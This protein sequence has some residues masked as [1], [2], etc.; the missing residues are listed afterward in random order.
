MPKY[1][2]DMAAMYKHVD[3]MWI[4]GN[5]IDMEIQAREFNGQVNHDSSLQPLADYANE[6]A[7]LLGAD[8]GDLI[9]IPGRDY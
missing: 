3:H 6:V 5:R 8:F 4:G 9:P 2:Y 1:E 7:F